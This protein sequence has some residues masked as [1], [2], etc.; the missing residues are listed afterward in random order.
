MTNAILANFQRADNAKRLKKN[1]K[2]DYL[3]RDF[4]NGSGKI[5]ILV[6][7]SMDGL[8]PLWPQRQGLSSRGSHILVV[9][10]NNRGYIKRRPVVP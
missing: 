6:Y 5:Q 9:I 7:P 1:K 3:K 2:Q 10:K 8:Y 4:L